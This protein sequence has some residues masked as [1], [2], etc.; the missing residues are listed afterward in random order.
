MYSTNFHILFHILSYLSDIY[1]GFARSCVALTANTDGTDDEHLVSD[2]NGCATDPSIFGEWEQ[3]DETKQLVA[4]F[5]AFKFP[6]SNS[7]R[8][9]CNVRVCFGL[10]QPINCNGYDAFGKRRR[11]QIEPDAESLFGPESHFEGQLREIKVSSQAILTVESRTERFTAPE[12]E[13]IL[14]FLLDL[15]L[16]N[17]KQLSSDYLNI[18]VTTICSWRI[19]L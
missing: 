5:S 19:K 6:S 1:G 13:Y 2:E 8:F 10:C 16:L 11:R 4:L 18:Y 12:S 15:I 7:I 14:I 17:H 9:Q 3:E